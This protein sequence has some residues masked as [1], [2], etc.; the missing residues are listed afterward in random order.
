MKMLNTIT[1]FYG[2]SALHDGAIGGNPEVMSNSFLEF[3]K[4]MLTKSSYDWSIDN[5]QLVTRQTL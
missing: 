2:R 4:G 1:P 3:I 5:R